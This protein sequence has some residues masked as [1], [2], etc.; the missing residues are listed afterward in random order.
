MEERLL[1]VDW[2][3]IDEFSD[4]EIS[5]FLFV[6]GKSLEIIAKIRNIN[7]ETVQKH[8]IDGKIKYR[9][10][11]KSKDEKTLFEAIKSAGKLDKLTALNALDEEN[12]RRLVEYIRKSYGDMYTKDKEI[13][14]WILGEIKS[15]ENM[16]IFRKASVHNHVNVRRMAVSALGKIGAQDSE[17]ILIRTLEDENPQVVMYSIKALTKIRGTKAID[18]LKKIHMSTDKEYIKKAIDEFMDTVRSD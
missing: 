10:L 5:Y 1:N 16:D 9:F 6:E 18:K 8:I 4:E 13:A 11:A 15:I 7:R 3:K 14:V 2:S 12:R 17:D